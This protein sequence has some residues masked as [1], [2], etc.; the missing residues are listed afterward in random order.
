M[1]DND[2]NLYY[3][4]SLEESEMYE[5][6]HNPD[7]LEKYLGVDIFYRAK[8]KYN[9]Y[10]PKGSE[11]D[12]SRLK[13]S[14]ELYI[15]ESDRIDLFKTWILEAMENLKK[16]VG[17]DPDKAKLY[18]FEGTR[19][20]FIKPVQEIIEF[21]ENIVTTV[22]EIYLKN[23]SVINTLSFKSVEKF[24]TLYHSIN[25]MLYSI[26]FA[27][28]LTLRKPQIELYGLMGLLHDIGYNDESEELVRKPDKLKYD[29]LK[30]IKRHP[31]D[32]MKILKECKLDRRVHLV[33]WEHHERHDGTG[34]PRGK[35][36]HDLDIH[37][38]AIAIIDAF[39]ALTSGRPHRKPLSVLEALSE[40]KKDTE[41][42]KLDKMFFNKFAKC[43]VG[44]NMF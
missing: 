44:M 31:K 29:E 21:S 33:A 15:K 9:L 30:Q 26:A 22:T 40:I 10:R 12:P 34:Y 36:V 14:I 28:M 18:L 1:K 38:R 8:S 42:G 2:I 19:L 17:K 32:G 20:L 4:S 35:K 43:F 13:L 37:T 39:E 11:I 3:D 25:V 16:T 5:I 6:E 24:S 23:T 41:N 7:S 27:H